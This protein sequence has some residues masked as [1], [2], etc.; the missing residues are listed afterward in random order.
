M[1]VLTLQT[2][3]YYLQPKHLMPKKILII[4][5]DQGLSSNLVHALEHD[6]SVTAV[7]HGADGIAQAKKEKPD[8]IILDVKLPDTDGIHVLKELKSDN[9]TGGIPVIVLTNLDDQ[10]TVSSIIAAG[11]KEYLVKADWGLEDIA[12]KISAMV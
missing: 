6:Y 1:V 10:V 7:D 12:R 2:T 11:G 5:D 9:T 8:L 3:D 4:E